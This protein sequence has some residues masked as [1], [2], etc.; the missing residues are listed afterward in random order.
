MNTHSYEHTHAYPICMKTS[1]K[2][3][4]FDLEIYKVGHQDRLIIDRDVA[5]H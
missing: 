3:S 1:E 5:S 2:L 4:W